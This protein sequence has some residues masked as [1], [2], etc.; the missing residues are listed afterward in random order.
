MLDE[1]QPEALRRL[2]EVWKDIDQLVTE[3]RSKKAVG[4]DEEKRYDRLIGE[5]RHL[6]G[7]VSGF[8]G[9]AGMQIAGRSFDAF[10]HILGQ[11]SLYGIVSDDFGLGLWHE[12][13]SAGQSLI[14]QTIG[15]L[16]AQARRGEGHESI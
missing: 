11:G 3:C 16:D 12:L 2:E 8:M 1:S 14:Q 9:P 10:Q 13:W 4:G 7:Q 15:K 6:Y 5:A